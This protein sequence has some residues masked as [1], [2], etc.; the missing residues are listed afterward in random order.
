MSEE[1][2]CPKCNSENVHQNENL[3]ICYDCFHEWDPSESTEKVEEES[4]AKV[5]LDANGNVLNDGD[6]VL[7]TKD[8][9]SKGAAVRA[10]TKVKNIRLADGPDGHNI[11]CKIENIGAMFLKSEFVKKV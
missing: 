1:H 10:G 8:L 3:M 7:V 9:K 11:S 5:V 6:T 2:K 4:Q